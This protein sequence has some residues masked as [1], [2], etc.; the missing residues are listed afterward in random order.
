[1]S[2]DTRGDAFSPPLSTSTPTDSYQLL[3]ITEGIKDSRSYRDV[4][5]WV[6][7]CFEASGVAFPLYCRCIELTVK[8]HARWLT[9][10]QSVRTPW[11]NLTS[12][13]WSNHRIAR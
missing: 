5:H 1:M 10:C 4:T 2:V 6:I 7:K 13:T 9:T 11:I 12:E 3:A 8:L